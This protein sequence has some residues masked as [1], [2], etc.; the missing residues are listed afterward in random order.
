MI[1]NCGEVFT[2]NNM[3]R[4][5]KPL[6]IREEP[7]DTKHNF[8]YL[9]PYEESS[10]EEDYPMLAEAFM[11]DEELVAFCKS[12]HYT[13]GEPSNSTE[14]KVDDQEKNNPSDNSSELD[15]GKNN[16]EGRATPTHETLK[17][18][19]PLK[20]L[21]KPLLEYVVEFPPEEPSPNEDEHSLRTK[22]EDALALT[23]VNGMTLLKKRGSSE[24]NSE[25]EA[26][27]GKKQRATTPKEFDST[28]SGD[29]GSSFSMGYTTEKE[30][31][32]RSLPLPSQ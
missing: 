30:A 11:T 23:L 26:N 12:K 22:E 3:G 9:E 15:H 13:K 32:G 29:F 19:E 16:I 24:E 2:V 25:K 28:F 1:A 6:Q 31:A 21:P 4:R 10:E 20:A 14:V 17:W 18:R 7:R 8:A 5:Y 27:A